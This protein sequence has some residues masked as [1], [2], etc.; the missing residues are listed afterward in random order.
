[1]A[2]RKDIV[3]TVAAD[4][5]T[6]L[7]AHP[8]DGGIQGEDKA[9]QVKFIL[10]AEHP[11]VTGDYQIYI[12]CVDATGGY[13]KTEVLTPDEEGAITAL[14]P[15]AWTQ[16]GGS[17]TLSVVG[18]AEAQRIILDDARLTFRS[19][20]GMIKR[21]QLLIQTYIQ[22][23]L[24][25]A[26]SAVGVAEKAATSA[27]ESAGKAVIAR[28][29]AQAAAQTAADEAKQAKYERVQVSNAAA[30]VAAQKDEATAAA[31][32]AAE[33][34]SAAQ[35][36]AQAAAASASVAEADRAS[37]GQILNRCREVEVDCEEYADDAKV[38][39]E[40]ARQAAKRAEQ[41]GGGSGIVVST[42]T[43]P[44]AVGDA[45]GRVVFY[46]D[47]EGESHFI[48]QS[49][50]LKQNGNYD[51]EI[52]MFICYGQSWSTGYDASAITTEPRYDNL[53]L[54]TGIMTDPLSD[55]TAV[56][57]SFLPAVEKTQTTDW[58]KGETPVSAQMNVVKQL[59]ES[60]DGLTVNDLSYQLLGTAPGMG[61]KT[62][63]Q[64]A[65][66]TEYY[67]RLIAQVQQAHNIAA[68]MGKRLV[69]Q[70]FSWVQGA[71]GS[72]LTG[73]YA[74]NLE[75][76]RLDI[77]TD[78]KAITG[79]TQDVKC[80][81]WQSFIYNASLRAKQVYD[82]YVGAAETY[83]N[84]I[85][86]GA[87]Y[88]LDNVSSANLHFTSESQDWLGAYFGVSY[89]RTIIDGEEFEPLKPTKASKSGKILYVKFNVPQRPLV[90]DTERLTEA[91]NKGFKLYA[92]DGT[93]KTITEVAIIS[94]DTVKIVCADDVASTDR[95]TY[96][97]ITTD[98][99]QWV[100]DNHG[101]L[102]DSQ[103]N[104]IQYVTDAYEYYGS[105]NGDNAPPYGNIPVP[106]KVLPV[107]NWCVIFDK[108]I[109]ELE[110]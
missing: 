50:T 20:P 82:Q 65:K 79:Q 106:S 4:G 31:A 58:K 16:Y 84:I 33:R 61:S 75:K 66:G 24:N 55:L 77:D 25:R 107:H 90:F 57:T 3:W 62:L 47:E 40:E 12:E 52:N 63:A 51:A 34:A 86:A 94:P 105:L 42:P 97:E 49:N 35:T 22:K 41:N 98:T 95:L 48:E 36:M 81:T 56:A 96:G 74:E 102:R 78:V 85:C 73:T 99:Y 44:Y 45:E 54:D 53:M 37:A 28:D 104:Y 69:V 92:T 14:V 10:G 43:Y 27:N 71:L 109:A 83:P 88:H 38:A 93:E 9:V 89:K 80:I 17:I 72:G 32:S 76:L 60:E 29:A 30:A 6:L 101:N 68:A 23:L 19:R 1:M 7:P 59:M 21:M 70:A 15:L 100:S 26:E 2:I 46:I 18:E 5:V 91:P 110:G 103:G 39:A 11:L 13:D 67:T 108:T 87:T 64:L 8:Q